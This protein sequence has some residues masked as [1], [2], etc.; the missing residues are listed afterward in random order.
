MCGLAQYGTGEES[1]SDKGK[2]SGI[3]R[4]D[5]SP[6]PFCFLL[7]ILLSIFPL[8]ISLLK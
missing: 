1:E 5:F 3:I 7:F 4:K 6:P 8:V 2:G